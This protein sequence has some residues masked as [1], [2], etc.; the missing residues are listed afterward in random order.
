MVW[1]EGLLGQHPRYLQERGA[2]RIKNAHGSRGSQGGIQRKG[3]ILQ[4]RFA[5]KRGNPF[6][7]GGRTDSYNPGTQTW[8]QVLHVRKK[9][10]SSLL[11]REAGMC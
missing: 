8:Q 6:W 9:K 2:R 11:R 1:R 5:G 10:P 3:K 7:W 4:T